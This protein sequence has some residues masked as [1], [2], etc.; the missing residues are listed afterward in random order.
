MQIILSDHNCEGQAQ[1]IFNVLIWDGTWLELV[2]MTLKWF[3]D[4][5]LPH[6]TDDEIVWRFCQEQGYILLTGNRSGSDGDES[7][8]QRIRDL[9]TDNCLPVLTIGNL[10]RVQAD[11]VYPERCAERLAEIVGDLKAYRGTMRLFL[12]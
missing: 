1:A 4:V 8:E 9:N 5:N 2:P 12:P 10:K 6:S 11:P 3:R 7:L